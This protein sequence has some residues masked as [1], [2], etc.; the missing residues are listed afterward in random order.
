MIKISNLSKIYGKG[1]QQTIALDNISL[2]LPYNKF[3]TIVGKSG[4]GKTTLLNMLGLLDEPDEGRLYILDKDISKLSA[5]ERLD[6]RRNKIGIVFQFFKLIS[7]LTIKENI[8]LANKNSRKYDRNYFDEIVD[9]L[10]IR[11][12][13]DKYP[14]QVSG[15][16]KQRAAIARAIINKPKILL[17]DEPTGNLDSQNSEVVIELL[18][19]LSKEYGMTLIVV[20]HDDDIRRKS[21]FTVLL[22]DGNVMESDYNA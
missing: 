21:D 14:E 22:E 16:Q 10:D 8:I 18:K 6:Y 7:V 12:I 5:K 1:D 3:I 2:E 20:T 11:D 15:G 17:A 4:S 13:L 19:K 9:T